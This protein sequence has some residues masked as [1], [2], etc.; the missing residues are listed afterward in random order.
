ML[1]LGETGCGKSTLINGL[2]NMF[3]G[4]AM[5][6]AD[7]MK[8]AIKTPFLKPSPEYA[9]IAGSEAGGSGVASQTKKCATY[10]MMSGHGGRGKFNI[11][12]SPGLSDTGGVHQDQANMKQIL[13]SVM[14]LPQ[15]GLTALVLV[16]NGTVKRNTINITN[17]L[18][19]LKGNMPDSV[20]QN[21]F[22]VCTNCWEHTCNTDQ[23]SLLRE[24]GLRPSN[25]QF[26]YV[27]NSAFSKD[28]ATWSEAS[29]KAIAGEWEMCKAELTRLV[30]AIARVRQRNVAAD[31]KK[32]FEGR[33]KLM[34]VLHG[35]KL[36]AQKLSELLKAL[37]KADSMM[38]QHSGDAG[39]YANFMTTESV[40]VMELVD[41]PYHST[42][43]RN[44]NV[45]CM[46]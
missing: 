17:M 19:G 38:K 24:L 27:Q 37:D 1:L 2:A 34:G 42:I 7:S 39:K 23:P 40:T 20:M 41:A 5:A 22:V 3:A 13:S 35:A 45:V 14:Q 8:V 4:S 25:A 36:E 16:L 12:D 44:C 30:M 28:P 26:F 11:V 29:K 15:P 33:Q 31:F 43:C 18:A 32:I 9:H 10:R 6:G 21:V 46:P